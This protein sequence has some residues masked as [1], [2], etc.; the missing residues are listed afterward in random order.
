MEDDEQMPCDV[1]GEPKVE[2]TCKE[3][4]KAYCSKHVASTELYECKKCHAYFDRDEAL[5]SKFRCPN[6]PRSQCPACRSELK[7]DRLPAG[8]FYLQCTNKKCGWDSVSTPPILLAA[9]TNLA[10]REG[11]KRGWVKKAKV[12]NQPLKKVSGEQ[13]CPNCLVNFL[14][15]S[16]QVN[17]STIAARFG[18]TQPKYMG[19]VLEKLLGEKRL[20]GILDPG[21]KMFLAISEQTKEDILRGLGSTGRVELSRYTDLL[22][23]ELRQVK[24]LVSDIV[25]SKEIPGKFSNDDAFF[26]TEEYLTGEIVNIVT[27][28]GRI[29]LKNLSGKFN[30]NS[31]SIK[32][33]CIN[34]M[35]EK[36]L[37][38]F[39]ADM[40]NE[41]VTKQKLAEEI[42]SYARKV[43]VFKLEDAASTF[44]VALEL[45]RRTIHGLVKDGKLRGIF[46]QKR[47]YITE[48]TLKE[49]IKGFARAYRQMK[50]FDLARKLGVTEATVEDMLATLIS[51]GAIDGYIDSANKVFV[52]EKAP[53]VVSPVGAAVGG[54]G[55]GDSAQD[56]TEDGNVEVVREYDFMGGQ[57]HFKVVVRNFTTMAIHDIKVV[58]DTPSSFNTTQEVITIPVIDPGSTRGVDFY[59]E[60]DSCGISKIGG[61]VIYKNAL[62]NIRTV[63]V[64]PKEVQI[65]CPLVVKTLDTIEDCQI[66]IQDLPSD[67]R[68]FLIADLDPRLAF[69]AAMRAI[70]NF[71]TRLVT[72]HE[73][74]EG[75]FYKA[76]AWFSS[77]AKVTGGRI[78][79]RI[80]VSGADQS[81][82]L[83]IWC[84][85]PGQLT[86]FLAKAIEILFSE[87]NIIRKVRAEGRER[88][89]DL[90]ALTQN[91]MLVSNYAEL[92]WKVAD[93][94]VKVQDIEARLERLLPP[95]DPVLERLRGWL[96]HF[97]NFGPEDRI[98]DDDAEN[99]AQDMEALQDYLARTIA[100]SV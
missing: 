78:I 85:N 45:V 17:Y 22:K 40:G 56:F 92:R 5:K 69:R 79:T 73:A 82:E 29:S 53:S 91:I 10:L 15:S 26:Y 50:L 25:T 4:G 21:K 36:K 38:A 16:G 48:D 1:C 32:D 11:F 41:I 90:M 86:G 46:T 75:G 58:L 54:S 3:C 12:C 74:D 39:F 62:G 84:N 27:R 65:K 72:S 18:V 20:Y 42:R 61:T 23:V 2:Y 43:G 9:T 80:F 77:K 59:L 71:D 100:P 31:E 44:K 14:N 47:E 96:S 81:L 88:T 87:I 89:I 7:I 67:A 13:V 57:L 8:Q 60:P 52:V 68:A 55:S 35:K 76:E 33:Y 28:E 64:R 70:L 98:P 24:K 51:H 97:Q 63:Y 94:E 95:T 83:R 66:A 19:D 34:L 37:K 6:I 99:L 49:K 30:L 93:I